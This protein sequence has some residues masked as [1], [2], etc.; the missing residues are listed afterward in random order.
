MKDS[1]ESILNTLKSGT[2]PQQYLE[3]LFKRNMSTMSTGT[4]HMLCKIGLPGIG[5]HTSTEVTEGATTA[6]HIFDH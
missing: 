1:T 3:D 6:D 5:E 4:L 2:Y